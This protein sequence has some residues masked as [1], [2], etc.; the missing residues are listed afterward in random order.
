MTRYLRDES[1]TTLME[2]MLLA[3]LIALLTAFILPDVGE[4]VKAMF[5]SIK[6]D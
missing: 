3:T 1:G 4:K 5:E 6:F 2:Y